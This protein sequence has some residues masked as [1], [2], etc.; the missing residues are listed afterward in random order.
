M[1]I[2][3]P[4][5]LGLCLLAPL[6]AATVPRPATEIQFISQSGE[7]IKLSELKGKV[8]IVEFLLT[9]CPTCKNN[10][11]M[12]GALQREYDAKGLRVIGLAIDEGAGPKIPGFVQETNSTFP[13]GVYQHVKAQEFLQFP[14]VVRMMMPQI[15][16]IDRKGVI[17]EQH[18]ADEPWMA[19]AIEESNLRKVINQL[20]AEPAGAAAAPKKAA[21][22][23]AAPKKADPKK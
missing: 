8:V 13:I 16:I 4:A 1:R 23:K 9:H 10:A 14:S 22:K 17:R 3:L 11:R 15:A 19:P 21:P 6:P 2:L 20:L 7:S 18:G 5:L 12:L